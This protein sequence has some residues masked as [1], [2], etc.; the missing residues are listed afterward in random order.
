MGTSFD[1][2]R[3]SADRVVDGAVG[4][5]YATAITGSP[6]SGS[7]TP[8]GD[9]GLT[10]LFHSD[11]SVT[12]EGFKAFVYFFTPVR[13]VDFPAVAINSCIDFKTQLGIRRLCY[14]ASFSLSL[15]LSLVVHCSYLLVDP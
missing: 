4:P 7:G 1:A 10:A 13:L 3:N 11:L 14:T 2:G 6:A 8:T 5:H 9:Y 15:S 12:H